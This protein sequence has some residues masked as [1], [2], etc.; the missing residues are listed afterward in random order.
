[1]LSHWS[2]TVCVGRSLIE[3]PTWS[4]SMEILLSRVSCRTDIRFLMSG[5][6]TRML[7][8]CKGDEAVGT[9]VLDACVTGSLAPFPT[10]M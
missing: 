1:V 9:K 3:K 7:R 5:G 10:V 2:F 6:E 8:R 4:N